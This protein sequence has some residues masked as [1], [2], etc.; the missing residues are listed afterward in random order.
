R[1]RRATS[2]CSPEA[3]PARYPEPPRPRAR[4]APSTPRPRRTHAPPAPSESRAHPTAERAPARQVE[5]PALGAGR[6]VVALA[7][8]HA[9]AAEIVRVPDGGRDRAGSRPS[10]EVKRRT[11]SAGRV[12]SPADG[13]ADVADAR[14]QPP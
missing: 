12:E 11:R 4:R 13:R 2:G 5:S 9:A 14:A 3:A 10:R 1:R 6:P 7:R 8:D